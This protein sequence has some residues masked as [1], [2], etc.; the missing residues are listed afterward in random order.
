MYQTKSINKVAFD[1]DLKVN[2]DTFKVEC[3][4]S[5]SCSRYF[6]NEDSF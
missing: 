1:M 6:L 5:Q 3:L 2:D 4:F